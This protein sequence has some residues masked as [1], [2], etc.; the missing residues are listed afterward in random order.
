MRD[1]LIH[2]TGEDL[3]SVPQQIILDRQLAHLVSLFDFLLAFGLVL[4]RL[5][6]LL[7]LP[8]ALI[9]RSYVVRLLIA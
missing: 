5:L 7:Y 4:P 1:N 2:L 9:C 8:E 3:E 6:S